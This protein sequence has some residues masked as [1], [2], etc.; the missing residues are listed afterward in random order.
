MTKPIGSRFESIQ[1]TTLID[2]EKKKIDNTPLS[3]LF[4][5]EENSNITMKDRGM[6]EK[7]NR[8][9]SET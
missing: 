8:V 1:K 2:E 5:R 9:Y 6:I 3:N 4:L 7:E